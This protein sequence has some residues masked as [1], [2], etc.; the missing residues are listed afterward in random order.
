MSTNRTWKRDVT[1]EFIASFIFWLEDILERL[2]TKRM[3]AAFK[4]TSRS[5]VCP[6]IVETKVIDLN[7]YVVATIKEVKAT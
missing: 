5:L 7:G 2:N 4:K 1:A 3:E 6:R